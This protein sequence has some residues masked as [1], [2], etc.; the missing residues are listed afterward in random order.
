MPANKTPPDPDES[1][2]PNNAFPEEESRTRDT[3]ATR[4]DLPV[5]LWNKYSN[6]K[7]S[8]TKFPIQI[9]EIK[10]WCIKNRTCFICLRKSSG[11]E[12]AIQRATKI[13]KK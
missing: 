1:N 3:K 7:D 6:H 8:R 4:K 9:E 5:G 12:S 13:D 11:K 10:H 2:K